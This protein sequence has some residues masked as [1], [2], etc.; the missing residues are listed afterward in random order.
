MH[1]QGAFKYAV[2][3]GDDELVDPVFFLECDGFDC[4][5]TPPPH[6]RL[7]G[8]VTVAQVLETFSQG[9]GPGAALARLHLAR[10]EGE[11]R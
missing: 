8:N 1:I 5:D 7:T 10:L 9:G 6:D 11:D 2:G 4:Q 3:I